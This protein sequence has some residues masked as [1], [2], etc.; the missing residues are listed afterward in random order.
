M[1]R[2]LFTGFVLGVGVAAAVPWIMAPGCEGVFCFRAE[3]EAAVRAETRE[4]APREQVTA[5]D[6]ERIWLEIESIRSK[7]EAAVSQVEQI[8]VTLEVQDASQEAP[9]PEDMAL[10]LEAA[11]GPSE[12][13]D[14]A[15]QQWVAAERW[16]ELAEAALYEQGS[17]LRGDAIHAVGLRRNVDSVAVLLEVA[18]HD[19]EPDNRYQA[20][21]SLWYSAADG[22]DEDGTI[23]RT[24]EAALGDDEDIADLAERALVDLAKL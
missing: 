12:E 13:L 20:L 2:Y 8:A 4:S 10:M 15:S 21:Q 23:R 6:L 1:I 5:E 17:E 14:L 9:D 19:P 18:T 11:G 3:I 7:S 24:L 16:A 22:L